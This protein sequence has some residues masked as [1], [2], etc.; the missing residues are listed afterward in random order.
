MLRDIVAVT[1]RSI[2]EL[3]HVL[4]GDKNKFAVKGGLHHNTSPAGLQ[5]LRRLLV[6]VAVIE[7]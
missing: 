5:G 7:S 3:G 4:V 2:V 1:K 6:A